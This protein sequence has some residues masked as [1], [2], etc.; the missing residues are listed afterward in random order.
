LSEAERRGF[1][2]SHDA[3]GADLLRL[4]GLPDSIVEAVAF[5]HEP[6]HYQG[7]HFS[8]VTAVHVA[9]YLEHSLSKPAQT[10]SR[11]DLEHLSQLQLDTRIPN[12][13]KLVRLAA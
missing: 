11:L 13:E 3:V 4:W 7:A 2:A 6:R 8:S 5:H 10:N 9:N 1:S 12:W